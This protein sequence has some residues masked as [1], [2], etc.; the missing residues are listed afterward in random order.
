M[1]TPLVKFIEGVH[2]LL[3]AVEAAIQEAGEERRSEIEALAVRQFILG[4]AKAYE[5]PVRTYVSL[6]ANLL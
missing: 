3:A 2:E 1:T 4:A 6:P 5:E